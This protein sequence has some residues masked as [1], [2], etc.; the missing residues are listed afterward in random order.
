M[1]SEDEFDDDIKPDDQVFIATSCE[2]DSQQL[3]VYMYVE[4][5]GCMYVHH[6]VMLSA[7]PLCIEYLDQAGPGLQGCFG[8]VGL[9]DNSI[10]IWDLEDA[11]PVE[12]ACSL[13]PARKKKGKGKK[14]AVTTT[15]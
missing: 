1:G 11:D 14:R 8:A 2:E 3:E 12:P 6:D 9:I 13:G 4:E 15:L 5:D 10:Q 7:Y